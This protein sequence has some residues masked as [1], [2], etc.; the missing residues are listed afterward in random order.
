MDGA[1]CKPST[2]PNFNKG[3]VNFELVIQSNTEIEVLGQHQV[4]APAEDEGLPELLSLSDITDQ[5]T[6]IRMCQ[7]FINYSLTF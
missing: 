3:T 6:L 1:Y 7:C 4:D 2:N 5:A